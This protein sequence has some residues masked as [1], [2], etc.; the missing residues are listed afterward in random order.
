MLGQWRHDTMKL[1]DS[2]THYAAVYWASAS[3]FRPSM[4]YCE[5]KY[6]FHKWTEKRIYTIQNVYKGGA[7]IVHVM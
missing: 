3:W 2:W 1:Q 6:I 7:G 4:P 5:G